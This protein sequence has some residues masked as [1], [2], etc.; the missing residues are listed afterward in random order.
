M[1]KRFEK[2]F[3]ESEL[4]IVFVYGDT[5]STFAGALYAMRSGIRVG[6][7]ESELRSFDRRMPEEINR[8]LTD[9]LIDYLFSPTQTAVKNLKSENI[10]GKIFYTG[11]ISVEIIKDAVK[12]SSKSL[13]LSNLQLKPKSYF[14][15]TRH[16][17]ENTDS[18]DSLISVIHA[19]EI[20]SEQ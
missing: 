19:F 6:H 5:N 2:I 3:L 11:D 12:L 14:L 18:E 16:R 8:V 9:H 17:A 4:N 20:L 7:V 13:I 1:V 15:F 10:F